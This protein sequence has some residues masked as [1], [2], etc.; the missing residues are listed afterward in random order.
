MKTLV[1]VLIGILIIGTLCSYDDSVSK[2]NIENI[3]S[4]YTEYQD[5]FDT[6]YEKIL[7]GEH[8]N[9][10]LIDLLELKYKINVTIEVYNNLQEQYQI[11]NYPRKLEFETRIVEQ[12]INMVEFPANI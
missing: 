1:A 8:D 5:D 10:D 12:T 3:Y 4:S 11:S 7:Y 6:L 9:T 2:E